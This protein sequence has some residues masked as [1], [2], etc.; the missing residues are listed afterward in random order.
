MGCCAVKKSDLGL[1]FENNSVFVNSQWQFIPQILFVIYRVVLALYYT[2]WMLYIMISTF[3]WDGAK[4]FIYLTNWGFM[5]V[6][7]YLITAASTTVYTYIRTRTDSDSGSY[8]QKTQ[9]YFQLSWLL[10]YIAAIYAPL[11]S[12]VYWAALYNA[13]M[14]LQVIDFHDHAMNVI[15]MI[16]ETTIAAMP[17]RYIHA[18]YPFIFGV[19][20]ITN[21]LIYW[22]VTGEAV[23]PILDYSAKPGMATATVFACLAMV[24]ILQL[25]LW[26]VCRLKLRL[27][28]TNS[29]STVDIVAVNQSDT[30]H[31]T[32]G[33]DNPVALVDTA[34]QVNIDER[35]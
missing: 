30:S 16:L 32:P 14:G 34:S 7:I 5:A 10:Y 8:N 24:F 21:T 33:I 15:A 25:L 18:L 4:Y 23:Y 27:S 22:G 26:A 3:S 1:R 29:P 2:T 12:I 20:Y 17:V 28:G 19:C 9:W 13:E 35:I 6:T 31:N 11:L